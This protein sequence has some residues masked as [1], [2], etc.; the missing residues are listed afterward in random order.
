MFLKDGV[1]KY[2]EYQRGRE[3]DVLQPGVAFPFIRRLLDLNGRIKNY[4]PVEVILI[5]RN[6]FNTGMRVMNSIEHHGV[7]ISR[8]AFLRG[9]DPCQYIE[10]FNACL[11]L[12]A[13]EHDVQEAVMRGLPAGRVLVSKFK[14]DPSDHELRIAFDFDGVIA[15]DEA[16]RIVDISGLDA[17][18]KSDSI[19]ALEACNPG[20]LKRL[21]EEIGKIQKQELTKTES[22]KNYKSQIRVAIVTSRNAPNHKRC[23]TTLREWGIYPDEIFFLGGMDKGRILAVFR[24]H[25]FFDDQIANAE[26]AAELG[27]AV[28]IPV[29]ADKKRSA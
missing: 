6:D 21:V 22:D 12:S 16:E 28:H 5:S 3:N 23:I 13:N 1:E 4:S 26:T 2:R 11:F 24:P 25:I 9:G 7:P 20:P 8:A 17:F 19:K 18:R 14:D 29:P 15:D 10:P 27:P